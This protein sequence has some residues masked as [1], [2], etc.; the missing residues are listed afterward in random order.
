MHCERQLAARRPPSGGTCKDTKAPST[1]KKNI[2]W[3]FSIFGF[4]LF[5]GV[6]LVCCAVEFGNPGGA[7]E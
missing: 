7:N 1:K 5:S 3:G 4:V 6:V 2:L